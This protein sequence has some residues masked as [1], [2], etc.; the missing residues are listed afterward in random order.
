MK[1]EFLRRLC[2]RRLDGSEIK[3]SLMSALNRVKEEPDEVRTY[4]IITN[5]YL[6]SS[7]KSL[8]L[9]LFATYSL[10]ALSHLQAGDKEKAKAEFKR[11]KAVRKF[12][13]DRDGEYSELAKQE[14]KDFINA[15]HRKLR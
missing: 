15:M 1:S 13:I 9:Q 5:M 8:E 14:A 6:K 2:F 11:A 10:S 12:A 7:A 4:S 3:S